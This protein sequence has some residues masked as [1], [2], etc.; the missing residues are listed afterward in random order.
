MQPPVASGGGGAAHAEDLGM[1]S[2]VVQRLDEVVCRRKDGPRSGNQD[3]AD[4]DF[5]QIIGAARL[6]ERVAHGLEMRHGR[7][8]SAWGWAQAMQGGRR[9]EGEHSDGWGGR[10]GASEGRERCQCG[11]PAGRIGSCKSRMDDSGTEND[12]RWWDD[13]R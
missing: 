1:R 9:E 7:A 12:G 2:G 8:E 3:G 5:A 11:G 13:G 10:R 6:R 4:R